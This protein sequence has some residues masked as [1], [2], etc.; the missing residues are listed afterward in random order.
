[1]DDDVDLSPNRFII[2]SMNISISQFSL[3]SNC[4]LNEF[5]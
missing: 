3:N 4:F 5:L 1:M 2:Q